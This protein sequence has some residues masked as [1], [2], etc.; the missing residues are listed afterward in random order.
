MI[1]PR[2]NYNFVVTYKLRI[3]FLF[4]KWQKSIFWCK[5]LGRKSSFPSL[6][7]S[8]SIQVILMPIAFAGKNL[9][10]QML[11]DIIRNIP[12]SHERE[13]RETTQKT[14]QTQNLEL[15]F[16]LVQHWTWIIRVLETGAMTSCQ[17]WCFVIKFP[18]ILT[19]HRTASF[20]TEI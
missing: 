14:R 12:G 6:P 18:F 20:S 3:K 5:N 9:T 7:P 13:Q 17:C 4:E 1:F 16:S 10:K 11:T 8:P 15:I 19:S 2:I